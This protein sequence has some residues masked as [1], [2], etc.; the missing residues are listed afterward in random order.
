MNT[1]RDALLIAFT[2]L[3][4]AMGYQCCEF[5]SAVNIGYLEHLNVGY[6]FLLQGFC[7]T[8]E[9]VV[10]PPEDPPQPVSRGCLEWPHLKVSAPTGAEQ[11]I[12]V[13]LMTVDLLR[14]LICWVSFSRFVVV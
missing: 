10:A 3:L 11:P 7:P 14:F 2:L 1:H 8:S 12:L 4:A 5:V 6:R 9:P 13:H